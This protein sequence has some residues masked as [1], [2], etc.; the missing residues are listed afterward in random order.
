MLLLL[1]YEGLIKYMKSYIV[2]VFVF[3]ITG[4]YYS[5][6]V[7]RERLNFALGELK[8]YETKSKESERKLV[9]IEVRTISETT[10]Q[11]KEREREEKKMREEAVEEQSEEERALDERGVLRK[12]SESVPVQETGGQ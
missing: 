5:G 4:E 11:K 7:A 12:E 9:D 2:C 10:K 6:N 1:L 8:P 3:I